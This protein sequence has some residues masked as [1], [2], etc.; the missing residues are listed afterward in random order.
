MKRLKLR[1]H[2]VNNTCKHCLTS[3]Y[4]GKFRVSDGQQLLSNDRENLDVNTI[5]LVKTAPGTRLSKA[6]E[7]SAHHLQGNVNTSL[8][9]ATHTAKSTKHQAIFEI[10]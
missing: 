1:L 10:Y 6:R 2:I 3:T 8:L 5:E 9:H 4:P 7:K